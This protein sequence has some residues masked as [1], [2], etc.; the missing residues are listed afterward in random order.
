MLDDNKNFSSSLGL[1]VCQFGES[2][3]AANTF[4]SKR[5]SGANLYGPTD[6]VLYCTVQNTRFRF[7]PHSTAHCT[8][9]LL[10]HDKAPLCQQ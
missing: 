6:A 8:I 2:K 4:H 1:P 7:N 10:Q 3:N 5:Q 9:A